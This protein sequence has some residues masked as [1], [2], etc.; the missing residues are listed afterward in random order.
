MEQGSTTSEAADT[1]LFAGDAWFDPIE[2]G[3][4]ERVRGFIEKLL[5][6]ELTA[7]LGRDKSERAAGAPKGYRNGTRERQLLG[8]FGP[9]EV[10]VPRARM[11]AADGGTKEWRSAALPRYA[12]MTRQVEAL[13]ASAYL[14]GT[15]TRR[16]KRA[17][18]ALFGG[19]VGKDVVSRTWRKVRTDW[20]AWNKRDLADEDIVRLILD[21]TVVRVRLDRKATNISLLVVLGVRRDGQ[22]VLLAV[23]NMGGESEAAWRGILDGL[24]ARGL[25]TPEF[26]IT[27]GGAGLERALA[28]LWP[29]VPAQRCTVHKHRNPAETLVSAQAHA[30]DAL[31]EEV[32]SDYTDMIYAETAKEVQARR[33]AF[34]RKWCL[35]CPAVATSLE[36]AG[37][38]LFAFLRLPS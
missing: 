16:V 21:G 36:E 27:D 31:H 25:R 29:D 1:G 15:N 4:R 30:P 19:A 35:R 37:D 6:Q 26:L 24:I 11:S 9:V 34:L 32:T 28:A 18:A 7:A 8:S 5:E 33:R 22:K 3:I 10:E 14:S 13:I 20:D 38:R 17:L 12:R 2:A 23:K